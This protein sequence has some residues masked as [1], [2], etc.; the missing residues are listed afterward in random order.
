[1]T[2]E[3]AL[4]HISDSQLIASLVGAHGHVALAAE[5]LKVPANDIL[6]RL[7]SLPYDQ[8]TAAVKAS[9]LLKAHDAFTIMMEVVV[10]SLADMSANERGK[11]FIQF[12]DRFQTMVEPPVQGGSGQA[13]SNNFQFNLGSPEAQED[14]RASLATRLIDITSA[15]AVRDVSTDEPPGEGR[16][17]D[18]TPE[19]ASDEL[20]LRLGADGAARTI[21]AIQSMDDM[22]PSD[23]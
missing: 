2:T 11:F 15:R 13:P 9:R 12:M 10:Q 17:A 18:I 3:V 6:E 19:R 5:R 14:A 4:S 1:M 8:L 20:A 21:T 22:A 16:A 23:R 7:P